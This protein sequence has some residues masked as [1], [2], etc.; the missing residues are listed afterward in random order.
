MIITLAEAK[1]YLRV[2]VGDEDTLIDTLINA[3][4]ALCEDVSRLNTEEFEAAGNVAKIAVL[5]TLG[6]LHEHR[7]DAN[8]HELTLRLRSLLSGVRK[9][10]F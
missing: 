10:K 7:E 4:Q 2:D 1:E 3:A 8:H 6:Y 5:F 9:A